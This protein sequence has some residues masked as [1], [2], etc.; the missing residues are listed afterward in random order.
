MWWPLHGCPCA[1]PTADRTLL[2]CF[3]HHLQV[4]RNLALCGCYLRGGGNAA[5][6]QEVG[7]KQVGKSKLGLQARLVGVGVLHHL[8]AM[9]GSCSSDPCPGLSH[10][11]PAGMTHQCMLQPAEHRSAAAAASCPLLQPAP[12]FDKQRVDPTALYFA[13]LTSGTCVKQCPQVWWLVHFQYKQQPL[14]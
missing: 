2:A 11:P 12:R 7:S 8:A 1:S 9:Q 3:A 4:V 10:E 5:R 6:L 14:E 13:M